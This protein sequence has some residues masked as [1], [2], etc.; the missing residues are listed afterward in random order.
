MSPWKARWGFPR[1]PST[2]PSLVR[3]FALYAGVALILAGIAAFF[4]VREYATQHAEST[5]VAHTQYIADTV[6]PGKLRQSDFVGPVDPRRRAELD[7]IAKRQLLTPGI[8]RVKLYAPN[9]QVVYSSDHELIG[10]R[11]D[12]FEEIPD[13]MA[14]DPTSDVTRLNAEGGRGPDTTVLESYVPVSVGGHPAGVLE[15]YAD[16]GPIAS[17]ARSIFIPLAI[18]IC[19]LLLGLYLSFFPI[20]KR[21][22]RTLRSQMEE[23]QHKAY[24]DD[25]TDLPNR[26]LFN[27]RAEL[28]LREAEA[29]GTRLAV[30]LIDLDRFKDINDTL[31]HGS[32]DRLLQ[33]LAAD[34]PSY[35]REGDTVARLGGDEFG[36]LARGIGDPSAVLAL[37]QK[38]RAV[39]AHPRSID[40]IELSVDSSIGIALSPE[41][42][43]DVELLMRRADVAMYRSKEIHAPAL[44]ESE[45]DHYSPERLGLI[46]DLHGAIGGGELIV[47]YQPQ[48]DPASGQLVGVEALVRWLHPQRGLLMP[49]EFIPLAE[50]TGLI[51]EVTAHVLEVALLQ[52]REWWAAGLAVPVAVNI[53]A[54]DLLDSGFPEEVESTLRR[55][56]VDPSLLELE[57][58]EKSALTDLPR[59]RAILA[60]LHQ[61]GIRLAI[62][63]FGTGN[64]SLAYF[65]R[66]PVDVLKID[67]SF[68]M[69]ML[70]S[71]DDAAIVRSTVLLGHELGLRVVAEGVESAESNQWLAELGCDIVQGFYYGRAM[72]PEAI[73]HWT[74]G[75][76]G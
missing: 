70:D 12:D 36:I 21:V 53:S 16:Y 46:T 64:S 11:P 9:G 58:T 74:A 28:A 29:N 69:R 39:L 19:I 6:L 42:G 24:H 13:I 56:E 1:S 61:M 52:C 37:A 66:L 5:A 68:V 71:E 4:F 48:C 27:D 72:P 8:L 44:Y 30:M 26:T 31:G 10:T 17:D 43:G 33:A 57:I 60:E 63:D 7:R 76:L 67:R 23:I 59:A 18:G 14:G 25:L 40:G 47:D 38:V 73:G 55:C 62:D 22:T 32:G 34:L 49:D 15:L 65:R 50:H 35:M 51:R 54:R 41:D 3:R 75:Q 45:H 2:P 20:L